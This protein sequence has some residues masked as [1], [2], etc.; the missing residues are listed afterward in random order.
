MTCAMRHDCDRYPCRTPG[1][2]AELA[3]LRERATD[4]RLP[5]WL[6]TDD[7]RPQWWTGPESG[8]PLALKRAA[9][10]ARIAALP[11][12]VCT[13]TPII[14]GQTCAPP[15]PGREYKP[16]G[17]PSAVT[18]DGRPFWVQGWI[19]TD[20]TRGRRDAEA[21]EVDDRPGLSG[22]LPRSR[23]ADEF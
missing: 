13:N 8:W 15:S 22:R 6:A 1:V 20:A 16:W 17:S 10:S 23:V 11:A 3:P 19:R 12:T 5:Y 21:D 14:A 7:G 18:L 2:R 9:E 4:K